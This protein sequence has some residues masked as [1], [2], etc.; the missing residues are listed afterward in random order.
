MC[1]IECVPLGLALIPF[2]IDEKTDSEWS[3][4]TPKV[5]Q[6]LNLSKSDS[7]TC[8][9]STILCYLP[10]KILKW[11]FYSFHWHIFTISSKLSSFPDC[12]M[13]TALC[14]FHCKVNMYRKVK[15]GKS[16]F[17]RNATRIYSFDS[18][19]LSQWITDLTLKT[20]MY[21]PQQGGK[22]PVAYVLDINNK[23]LLTL[24]L[25]ERLPLGA[26]IYSPVTWAVGSVREPFFTPCFI[27]KLIVLKNLYGL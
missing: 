3:N 1:G 11:H 7:K 14:P 27:S 8:A 26:Q 9:H 20:Y 10:Y 22:K 15:F 18:K 12:T 25:I 23:L 4:N 21:K 17:F 13:F 19:M 6:H 24:L 5:T 2:H 16:Y